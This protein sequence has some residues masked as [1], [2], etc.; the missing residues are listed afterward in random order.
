MINPIMIE[1][2]KLRASFL[3][4]EVQSEFVPGACE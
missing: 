2:G 4:K 1:K 3:L